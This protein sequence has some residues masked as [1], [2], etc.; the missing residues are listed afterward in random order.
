MRVSETTQYNYHA[1]ASDEKHSV[2]EFFNSRQEAE[3]WLN[4]QPHAY[5]AL[6][7]GPMDVSV[8]THTIV[9]SLNAHLVYEKGNK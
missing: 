4:A 7:A 3:E 8:K 1:V 6:W 2:Y 5:K 9:R